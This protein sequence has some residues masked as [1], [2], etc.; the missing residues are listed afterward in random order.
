MSNLL[1]QNIKHTNGT[2]AQ[3]IDSSGRVLTP[4]RPAFFAYISSNVTATGIIAFD[5]VKYNQGSHFNTSNGTFTCPVAGLYL[6]NFKCLFNTPD[7]DSYAN[8]HVNGS[9]YTG[10]QASS[11]AYG[12]IGG[13]AGHYLSGGGSDVVSL[14]ASDAVT[15]YYTDAGTD[16][17]H[18]Y[19]TFSGCLIG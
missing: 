13:S 12:N 16:L 15:I 9:D 18:T 2:T 5:T 1:V 11:F 14:S 4:A 3:T 7:S 8:L 6:F 17:H 10:N 19:T